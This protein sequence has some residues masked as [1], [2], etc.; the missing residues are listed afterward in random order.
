MQTDSVSRIEVAQQRIEQLQRQRRLQDNR[1]KTLQRKI[2]TRMKIIIGGII[3]K[4]FPGVTHF[5]PGLN[6]AADSEEFAE[7]VDFFTAV[8]KD[9]RFAVLFQ[10]VVERKI[11]AES[12]ESG[13]RTDVRNGQ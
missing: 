6:R 1:D 9:E 12:N 4:I 3:T 2:D 5:R 11:L 10:E 7:L 13:S 8:A